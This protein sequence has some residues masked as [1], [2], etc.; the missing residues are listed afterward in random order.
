MILR[1]GALR[2]RMKFGLAL[3]ANRC[4]S[5]SNPMQG[6]MKQ[7]TC[8]RREKR[9]GKLDQEASKLECGTLFWKRLSIRSV[10]HENAP[11]GRSKARGTRHEY[12]IES[13]KV[14][15][16]FSNYSSH[17]QFFRAKILYVR[18]PGQP[19]L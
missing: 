6:I 13:E 3:V 14:D 17:V 7:H 5:P 15:L 4:D 12:I 8:L 1:E 11:E 19:S 16:D 2:T 10:L 9:T 18:K